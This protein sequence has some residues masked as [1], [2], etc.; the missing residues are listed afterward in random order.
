MVFILGGKKRWW[1]EE[2]IR[3]ACAPFFPLGKHLEVTMLHNIFFAPSCE[4]FMPVL[5]TEH[6]A[7]ER[8]QPVMNAGCH[9]HGL[10][11]HPEKPE[12]CQHACNWPILSLCVYIHFFALSFSERLLA[13]Q[14]GPM[15]ERQDETVSRARCPCLSLGAERIWLLPGV[16]TLVNS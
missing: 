12:S 6:D 5:Q 7:A 16:H 13:N 2:I 14:T 15:S 9:N 3:P 11:P 1:E 10:F 4:V 8:E